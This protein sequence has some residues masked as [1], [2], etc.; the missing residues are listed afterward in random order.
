LFF[1][2]CFFVFRPTLLVY[3]ADNRTFDEIFISGSM[4]PD[5]LPHNYNMKH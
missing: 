5:H 2:F 4:F 3:P 1:V